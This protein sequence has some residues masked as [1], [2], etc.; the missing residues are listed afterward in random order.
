MDGGISWLRERLEVS[1]RAVS[2]HPFTIFQD[3]DGIEFGQRW[4]RRLDDALKSARFLIPILTPSYFSSSSCRSEALKFLEYESAA[5]R[6]DLILPIYLISVAAF[7]H[8]RLRDNDELV[9]RIYERQY[10]DWRFCVPEIREA[11]GIKNHIVALAEEIGTSTQRRISAANASIEPSKPSSEAGLKLEPS[12]DPAS[13]KHEGDSEKD[14]KKVIDNIMRLKSLITMRRN[15]TFAEQDADIVCRNCWGFLNFLYQRSKNAD[16]GPLLIWSIDM[17]TR[18]IEDE[19]AFACYTNVSRL[20][21]NLYSFSMFDTI[22]DHG[23]AEKGGL[24]ARARMPGADRRSERWLVERSAIVIYNL[25]REEFGELYPD[26]KVTIQTIRLKG[27]GV[28]SE[29]LLPS[30][31]P[32]IW[33]HQLDE[34]YDRELE[35]SD[36]SFSICIGEKKG[37]EPDQNLE[38]IHYMAHASS[39][40]GVSDEETGV[41]FPIRSV[42]LQSPGRSYDEAVQMIQF[43]ARYRLGKCGDDEI[44]EGATAVAYLHNQGFRVLLL[45]DFVRLFAAS[46]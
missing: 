40:A 6:D 2:G 18:N 37:T 26:D 34:L 46:I 9:A 12:A 7:E 30:I 45:Q 32:S 1:V 19:D 38:T 8:E 14:T 29:H 36:V 5:K 35:A 24:A 3:K 27:I 4:P 16:S 41:I 15:S 39:S 42:E 28:S 22:N 20:A 10:R 33:R 21:A 11:P 43:A 13:K 17:G 25:R 44:E 31:V 23:G